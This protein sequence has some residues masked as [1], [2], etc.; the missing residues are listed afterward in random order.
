M[1]ITIEP[2]GDMA[3]LPDGGRGY[4]WEGVTDDGVPIVAVLGSVGCRPKDRAAFDRA[5]AVAGRGHNR[6]R[7]DRAR[8]ARRSWRDHLFGTPPLK[9]SA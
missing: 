7:C 3:E 4:L 9:G 1:R 5:F 6:R 2:T 8:P